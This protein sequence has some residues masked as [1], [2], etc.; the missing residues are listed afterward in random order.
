MDP[1]CNGPSLT[2]DNYSGRSEHTITDFRPGVA[3]VL[4]SEMT[5]GMT[6]IGFPHLTHTTVNSVC[7][8]VDAEA[9]KIFNSRQVHCCC[10]MMAAYFEMENWIDHIE[11]ETL[12]GCLFETG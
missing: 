10:C 8:E 2:D 12:F 11:D 1:R 5:H 4:S 6:Q 3:E 9:H 7:D